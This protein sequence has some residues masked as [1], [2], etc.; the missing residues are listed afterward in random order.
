MYGYYREKLHNNHFWKLEDGM[1]L[2]KSSLNL[3]KNSKMSQG[4]NFTKA[5]FQR[6]ILKIQFVKRVICSFQFL[7]YLA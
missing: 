5:I 2:K 6:M 3:I 4:T 1:T 7:K